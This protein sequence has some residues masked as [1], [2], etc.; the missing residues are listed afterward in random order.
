MRIIEQAALMQQTCREVDSSIVFVPTMGAL[1]EGHAALLRE[2]RRQAGTSGSVA[3]SIF[4]NPKQFGP[5]ED[6][7]RYP[8]TLAADRAL[9]EKEKVDLF[10][11][12]TVKEMYPSDSSVILQEKHLSRPLCGASRPGHFDG[13]ATV[14]AKLLNIVTPNVVIFGEKDWQ[15]LAFIRKT[16]RDLHFPVEVKGHP[17]VREKDGLAM[18][19][20]NKYLT[21]EERAAA[22]CIYQ[23]LQAAVA[24]A[25]AGEKNSATLLMTARTALEA[26]PG[27]A[28]DYIE[29]M[30]EE[31]LE[32]V[33]E[34]IFNE[35]KA[36]LFVAVKLGE[37]R[38]IDNIALHRK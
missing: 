5:H 1:H 9:C 24:Q 3:V 18:S 34:I 2:A 31:T 16:I 28:I 35:S 32:P 21:P 7:A 38:L 11:H 22:P 8:R 29:I 19:S 37:T 6:F 36:L 15:Q 30:N 10:F 17:I 12:P 13:V 27:A 23:A 25:G 33:S 14:I 26:I 4:V 20:R